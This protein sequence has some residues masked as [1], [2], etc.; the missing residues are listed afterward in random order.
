MCSQKVGYTPFSNPKRA[1][2]PPYKSIVMQR[3][4]QKSVLQKI[5][6]FFNSLPKDEQIQIL[7]LIEGVDGMM[8]TSFETVS[9]VRTD[10]KRS[11]STFFP[12]AKT[13]EA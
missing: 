9:D 6:E 7:T 10:I 8:V 3:I 4:L 11:R 2:F 1:A 5:A 13:T 12:V